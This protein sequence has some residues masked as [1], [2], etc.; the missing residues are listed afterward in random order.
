ML[1]HA[2]VVLGGALRFGTWHASHPGGT[3]G[4]HV[5]RIDIHVRNEIQILLHRLPKGLSH[6]LSPSFI[7]DPAEALIVAT[8]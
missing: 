5:D 4:A 1:S 2:A 6:H 8:R 3:S 7:G